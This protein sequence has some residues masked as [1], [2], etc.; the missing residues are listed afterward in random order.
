MY[1]HM[2]ASHHIPE[3]PK[4]MLNTTQTFWGNFLR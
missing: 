3:W 1:M 2:K 4:A